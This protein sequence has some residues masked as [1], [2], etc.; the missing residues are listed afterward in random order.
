M[1]PGEK[2]MK[3]VGTI[4]IK[5]SNKDEF[6]IEM[7]NDSLLLFNKLANIMT[8]LIDHGPSASVAEQR[9]VNDQIAR[10][11]LGD[12]YDDFVTS[13]ELTFGKKWVSYKDEV[14]P[15]T[16]KIETVTKP[17]IETV[18]EK[19]K[20]ILDS[21]ANDSPKEEIVSDKKLIYLL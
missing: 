18:V 13:Y 2:H 5:D 20:P 1:K 7:K 12:Q 11:I 10:E 3:R 16:K 17:V 6:Q 4:P 15:K 21:I 14:K 8:I 19:P 9:R